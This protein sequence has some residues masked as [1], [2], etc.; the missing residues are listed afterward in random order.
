MLVENMP[1]KKCFSPG[2]NITCPTFYIHLCRP[3]YWLSLVLNTRSST[4]Y[5]GSFISEEPLFGRDNSWR[6]CKCLNYLL[7][8]YAIVSVLNWCLGAG[9]WDVKYTP[10]GWS[11]RER[12]RERDPGLSA[13]YLQFTIVQLPWGI[14]TGSDVN[15]SSWFPA[16]HD[17]RVIRLLMN[18]KGLGRIR[19]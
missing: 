13:V 1:R 15:S 4:P 5:W 9:N 10:I 11:T 6:A 2:S 14:N 7:L 19:P 12:E 3:I 18:C 17:M 8:F 16:S